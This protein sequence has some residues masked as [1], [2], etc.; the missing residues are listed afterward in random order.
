LGGCPPA[1]RLLQYQLLLYKY[2]KKVLLTSRL[3]RLF[4]QFRNGIILRKISVH[5]GF[6]TEC[7]VNSAC[8]PK[9]HQRPF[10]RSCR[11]R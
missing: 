1:A 11:P 5:W 8:Y 3:Q 9:A 6:Q 10:Q 4:S 7:G 2:I